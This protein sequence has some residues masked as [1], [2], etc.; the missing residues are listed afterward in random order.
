MLAAPD[1]VRHF[2]HVRRMLECAIAREA[3]SAATP[4]LLAK[5]HAALEANR[6]ARDVRTAIATDVAFHYVLAEM[7]RNPV[8][9][10]LQI[11]L[12]EWLHEQRQTSVRVRGA[13]QAADAA[14]RR[15]Y[16][17]VARGDE[18]EADHA[19]RRHRHEVESFYWVAA[20]PASARRTPARTPGKT[21][22]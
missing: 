21:A 19:M 12:V 20:A 10:A 1:G 9:M 22:S 18:A 17:A 8:L 16:N 13:R 11:A 7:T 3:A 15:I 2:Q 6:T 5:L 14:P 4:Q